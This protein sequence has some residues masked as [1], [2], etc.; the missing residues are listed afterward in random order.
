[1]TLIKRN[2]AKVSYLFEFRLCLGHRDN[3]VGDVCVEVQVEAELL[4][5]PKVVR[6]WQPVNEDIKQPGCNHTI[7]RLS[8]T[9]TNY[10]NALHVCFSTFKGKGSCAR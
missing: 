1:M 9:T 7:V 6:A 10:R 8:I 4:L 2:M 3:M 5:S